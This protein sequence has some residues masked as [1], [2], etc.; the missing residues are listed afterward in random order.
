MKIAIVTATFPPYHGGMG[1]VAEQHASAF[2]HAGHTVTVY[3]PSPG[4]TGNVI[5][6][7]DGFVTRRLRPL[8]RIGNG[9]VLPQLA[10]LLER[11]DIVFLH[12]PA[13]GLVASTLL[14]AWTKGR[15]KKVF[16]YY[17]MD[18][19][20][21]GLRGMIFRLLTAVIDP[22]LFRRANR[23]IVSSLDYAESS[24]LTRHGTALKKTKAVPIGV[25]TEVFSPGV[26]TQ[27]S[28]MEF[29]LGEKNIL[30]VG[31][32]DR[33]HDFKGIPE[34]VRAFA[35]SHL[36]DAL[37]HLVGDGVLREHYAAEAGALGIGACVRFH[38][39]L[40]REALIRLY[41]CADVVVLP[42]R[43]RSEAFGMVLL[44]AMAS[45]IPVIASRLPGVRTVVVEGKTGWLVLPGDIEALA[46]ALRDVC[47][48]GARA[49]YMGRAARERM[50]TEYSI[51][52]VA[53][54]LCA[55]L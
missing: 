28:K 13:F 11:S 50:V 45:G 35:T 33:A 22:F 36:D 5:E 31:G 42:S 47:A 1:A 10:W 20:A 34:L 7:H 37:L 27:P 25:D 4:A 6:Q 15:T 3:A 43:G 53:K 55:L 49:S 32:M 44:E 52:V 19:V 14:W 48:D 51:D 54:Q 38:G 39:A 18:P 30:F 23:I 17:H 40:S 12:Y 21:T 9:A 2:A 29:R 41:R 8:V 26:C 16:V 46:A 24:A